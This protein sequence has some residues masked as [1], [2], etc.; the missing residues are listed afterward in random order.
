[1][2]NVSPIRGRLHLLLL[3][4]AIL[5]AGS[6]TSY[7][8]KTGSPFQNIHLQIIDAALQPSGFSAEAIGRIN[9]GAASQDDIQSPKF[10][11]DSHHCDNNQIKEGIDYF[12]DRCEHALDVAYDCYKNEGDASTARFRFG[13]GLHALQD[14][15]S[16]SNWVELQYLDG[17]KPIAFRWDLYSP[18]SRNSASNSYERG[19]TGP[20]P[21]GLK[22]GYFSTAEMK[23][24]GGMFLHQQGQ[25][26][27]QQGMEQLGTLIE[28]AIPEPK[29][30][31][32][33]TI[34]RAT[35]G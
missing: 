12:R 6:T 7:A 30:S 10:W 20:L 16:H 25:E 4:F 2:R 34:H 24:A 18:W 32:K 9:Q 29:C 11:I 31:T 33:F 21:A 22:T 8:F 27:F 17:Q 26:N 3:L 1:M 28:G 5:I 23:N 15:Y 19:W 14:F 35:Q 13:E